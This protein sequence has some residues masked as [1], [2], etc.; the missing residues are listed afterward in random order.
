MGS[1]L[2]NFLSGSLWGLLNFTLRFSFTQACSMVFSL[3]SFSRASWLA[4]LTFSLPGLLSFLRDRLQGLVGSI[5]A[6]LA[7]MEDCKVPEDAQ[8]ALTSEGWTAPALSDLALP[9]SPIIKAS[10]RLLWHR[11]FR[12]RSQGTPALPMHNGWRA[13][14][15]R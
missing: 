12:A 2:Q 4:R 1:G 11:A 3:S 14:I 8:S 6:Q 13:G 9:G 15:R 10:L 5:F 7:V